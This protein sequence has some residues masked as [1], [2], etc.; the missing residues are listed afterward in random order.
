MVGEDDGLKR[1]SAKVG[2]VNMN[3]WQL[4]KVWLSGIGCVD[5]PWVSDGNLE[6]FAGRGRCRCGS[7]GMSVCV[8][9]RCEFANDGVFEYVFD[10]A[11]TPQRWRATPV[12]GELTCLDG[13]SVA[14]NV[15]RVGGEYP[16]SGEQGCDE[17][18]ADEIVRECDVE[19]ELRVIV[20]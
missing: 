1:L 18:W 20:E 7:E 5:Y 11:A 9:G 12:S 2:D 10:N 14:S 17:V 19:G 6:D 4:T 15:D 16:F 3:A 8:V 13:P